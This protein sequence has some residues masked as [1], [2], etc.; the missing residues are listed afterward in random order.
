MNLANV[1]S[2]TIFDLISNVCDLEA[3]VYCKNES[4]WKKWLIQIG[5]NKKPTN[6]QI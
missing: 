5:N 3:E 6:Y 2:E 4:N 1:S